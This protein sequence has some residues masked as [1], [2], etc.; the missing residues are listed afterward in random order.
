MT[1]REGRRFGLTVGAA[2]CVLGGVFLFRGREVPAVVAFVLG[3]LLLAA[4][5]LI[6]GRLGPVYDAWMGLAKAMSKVTTP[7]FMGLVYFLVFAPMGILRR[8]TG[9]NPLARPG[10]AGV[11]IPR[12][13]ARRSDMDRQF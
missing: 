12:D 8:A 2:F 11:W 9:K 7:I 1:P 13:P 10:E 5:L 4:G 6:P 3:G